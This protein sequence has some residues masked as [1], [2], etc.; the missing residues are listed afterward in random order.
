MRE[1]SSTSEM[2]I[3]RDDSPAITHL[4]LTSFIYK[5]SYIVKIYC[6]MDIYFIETYYI[7][8][9]FFITFVVDITFGV[10]F[11]ITFV[12]DCSFGQLLHL[13]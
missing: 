13:V 8:C 5:A 9:R 3:C 7:W 1:V 4:K 11:F 12:V 2:V 10:I 6:C